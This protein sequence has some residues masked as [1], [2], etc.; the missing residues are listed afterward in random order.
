MGEGVGRGV[1]MGGC[2]GKRGGLGRGWRGVE[3]GRDGS[4]AQRGSF[5]ETCSQKAVLLHYISM[6]PDQIGICV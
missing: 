3:V 4:G 5:R 1:V 6:S 2:G